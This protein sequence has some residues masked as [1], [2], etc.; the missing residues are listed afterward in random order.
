MGN[1]DLALK[2]AEKATIHG[3]YIAVV[4]RNLGW[5]QNWAGVPRDATETFKK[6]M[7]FSPILHPVTAAML[8]TAYRNAGQMEAAESTLKS[9][10]SIVPGFNAARI[11]L[12]TI[13]GVLGREE[14]ARAEVREI[15]RNDPNITVTKYATP[16]LYRD[17][18][19]IE[20]W[21]EPLRKAGLPE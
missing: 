8:G 19:Y 21:L 3:P 10:L 14:E 11:I 15:L 18:N 4:W 7:R 1:H 9:A 17:S 16:N 6:A 12:V 5:I 20:Q 13:F 2:V